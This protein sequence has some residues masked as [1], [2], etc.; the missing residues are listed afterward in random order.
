MKQALIF[1]PYL[2]SFGGGEVY[3]FRFAQTLGQ[4]GYNIT[5]AWKAKSQILKLQKFH[6]IKFDFKCNPKAHQAFT[7]S[8]IFNKYHL[9]KKFDLVFFVS[10]GSI[11]F[12]FG[13]QNLLHFQVP[14]TNLSSGLVTKLKLKT[15]DKIIYNSNF[16]KQVVSRQIK[17]PNLVLYPPIN[18][19]AKPANKKK[20]ILSVGR[21]TQTL[22]N[23][24]QDFLVKSFMQLV[25]EGL[26]EWQLVLIGS[27]SEKQASGL[28]NNIKKQAANY[29]IKIIT[30]ANQS[31]L[32]KY[33][34]ESS[35]YWHAAGFQIDQIKHPEL[36]EHFGISTVEAMIAGC[37]P[38]V[39]NKGG[40]AEIVSNGKTGYL[41]NTQN[42]LISHTQKLIQDKNLIKKLSGSA[43]LAAKAYSLKEFQNNIKTIV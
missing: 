21:F 16:T 4:L 12:L 23:K 15:I 13:K 22:Q 11:P 33:Y 10:D 29:P 43:A 39:V 8:S 24:R 25:D 3:V 18:T 28:V 34:Q 7:K 2:D 19:Q 27:T 40:Q 38:V 31:L 9:T 14:F 42:E 26:K 1:S 6:N 30:N 20:T 17:H 37:V 36:V 35:I 32:K 41:F 5:F